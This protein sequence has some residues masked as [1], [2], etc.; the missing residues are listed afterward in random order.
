[1]C[2]NFKPVLDPE[3]LQRYFGVAPIARLGTCPE[4]TWPGTLAPAV[5]LARQTRN[6]DTLRE[7]R[8][9]VGLYGL[10]PYWAK[11]VHQGRHTY[12]AR[13]ETADAL[14][15]FKEAWHRGQRCIVPL[16]G[17]YEPC[18]ESGRAV[19]WYIQRKDGAPMGAAG[20]WSAW[21]APEGHRVLSFT[22]LTVNADG[23]GVM[24]RIHRPEEEKRMVAILAPERYGDWLHALVP[25]MRQ[26][27]H[28]WPAEDLHAEP[29]PLARD[30]A[31]RNM[32]QRPLF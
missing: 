24:D 14:V 20:L 8:L 11:G 12:N 10:L 9:G 2:A 16:E 18:W 31:D 27:L 28:R 17:F 1:M 19:R 26:F 30:T 22:L 29:A 25:Q 13:S 15:S 3:R 4:E 32:G 21:T 6:L 7:R 5:A 23:H